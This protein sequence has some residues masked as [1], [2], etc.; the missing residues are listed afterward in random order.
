[1]KKLVITQCIWRKASTNNPKSWIMH[2][3][4]EKD[5]E[6]YHLHLQENLR[7]AE[8]NLKHSFKTYL[9]LKSA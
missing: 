5:N 8:S 4:K 7:H 6:I 1:M 3:N 2:R 9:N